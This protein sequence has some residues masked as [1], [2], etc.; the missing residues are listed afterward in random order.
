[1]DDAEMARA[2]KVVQLKTLGEEWYRGGKPAIAAEDAAWYE[3][4]IRPV[5]PA[6][7]SFCA[8]MEAWR[9]RIDPPRG[10]YNRPPCNFPAFAGR[11]L[12]RV[13]LPAG[14]VAELVAAA[15]PASSAG[16]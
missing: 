6:Y 11:P 3:A 2:T 16:R 1:L 15:A 10:P 4:A 12:P 5:L 13:R 8:R 7:A 9:R 14:L